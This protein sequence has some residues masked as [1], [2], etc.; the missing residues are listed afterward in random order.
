M[1]L[2]AA[3]K[4]YHDGVHVVSIPNMTGVLSEVVRKQYVDLQCGKT[5][6]HASMR[7]SPVKHLQFFLLNFHHA[8]LSG[9]DKAGCEVSTWC[10]STSC[11]ISNKHKADEAARHQPNWANATAS[12]LSKLCAPQTP[13]AISSTAG[14]AEYDEAG[15]PAL[16]SPGTWNFVS[17]SLQAA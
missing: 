13:A 3:E 9:C 4:A 14:R 7:L 11:P 10:S 17:F 15:H 1:S 5:G 2:W 12:A 8:L 6:V 16:S